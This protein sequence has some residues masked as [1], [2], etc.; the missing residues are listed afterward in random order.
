MCYLVLNIDTAYKTAI[1]VKSLAVK[2]GR[3]IVGF[4]AY[5]ISVL[6]LIF[7]E[8]QYFTCTITRHK[9]LYIYTGIF[10]VS[11]YYY[12]IAILIFQSF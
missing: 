8:P 1:L 6:K 2:T 9:P 4:P 5:Q 7:A 12:M 11:V 3:S 10:S